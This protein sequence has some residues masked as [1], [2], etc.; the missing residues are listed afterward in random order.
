[1]TA[2]F[3]LAAAV[4]LNDPDPIRWIAVYGLAAIISGYAAVTRVPR[5]AAIVLA[6]AALAWA[7]VIG[8]GGPSGEEYRQM[9]QAWEMRSPGIEEARET[10]G[11]VIV[12]AWMLALVM[13]D[14]RR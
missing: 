6:A 10:T 14:R 1:M 2:L 7:A 8:L 11:L 4:Q 13:R 5:R 3:A 9:F 12:A